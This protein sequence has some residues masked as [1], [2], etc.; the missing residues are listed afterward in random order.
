MVEII[1][2]EYLIKYK[3]GHADYLSYGDASIYLTLIGYKV[4][5]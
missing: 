3:Y 2:I 4:D 1:F 5:Y